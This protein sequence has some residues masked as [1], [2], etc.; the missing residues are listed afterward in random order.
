[1]LTFSIITVTRNAAATVERTLRSVLSQTYEGVE[2][3]VVD[4]A[5][6][7]GTLEIVRRYM[8]PEGATLPNGVTTFPHPITPLPPPITPL[9]HSVDSLPHRI[10]TLVSEPDSGL[11]DAMNKGLA[12]ATGQYVW[13]LNAGDCLHD[14]D[15]VRRVA[16]AI[17]R[18]AEANGA[19]AEQVS[20]DCHAL[21][22]DEEPATPTGPDVV[23]G[24][25]A[26][27]DDSGRFVRMRRLAP[28]DRLTWR[29]FRQGMLVCHQAFVARRTLCPPYYLRYRYSADYD[30]CIRVMRQAKSLHHTHLVLV[31]YLAQGLTTRHHRASLVERLRIMA[32]HYGWPVALAEHLW[33]VVRAIIRR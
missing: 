17:T 32:S 8:A 11:Y 14:A 24:F 15:T 1:M 30:W 20:A 5:S 7:D 3:I 33:F 12:L 4:G 13:F 29:S 31:D 28:P 2:Y 19:I 27:V 26:I 21:P 6:T 9:P 10:T 25:T 16:D 22:Q 18:Y 23:Y